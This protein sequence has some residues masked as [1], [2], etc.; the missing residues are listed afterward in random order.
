[1]SVI[2]TKLDTMLI[3]LRIKDVY[4]RCF[5]QDNK[6]IKLL[7]TRIPHLISTCLSLT[8]H[9]AVYCIC[10]LE[11]V[12]TVLSGADLYYWFA[13]GFGEAQFITPFASFF[14]LQIVGSVVSLSVQFFFRAS[15]TGT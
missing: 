15:H 13:A 2:P 4:S 11:T 12:Q 14:D 5:P 8:K 10:F 6:Y 3:S 7:G 1:M 9:F